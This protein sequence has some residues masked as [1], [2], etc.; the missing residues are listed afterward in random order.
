M[1]IHFNYIIYLPYFSNNSLISALEILG[2]NWLKCWIIII[3]TKKVISGIDE[4]QERFCLDT[5]W[6]LILAKRPRGDLLKI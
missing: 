1:H 2:E 5:V 6:P 4:W 3:I